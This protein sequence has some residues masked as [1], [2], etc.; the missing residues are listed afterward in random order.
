[1]RGEEIMAAAKV[2][3]TQLRQAVAHPQSRTVGE[4]IR[5]DAF[6]INL[7]GDGVTLDAEVLRPP[8]IAVNNEPK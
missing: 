5:L 7:A 6:D 2:D 1:M 3:G 8:D 4:R